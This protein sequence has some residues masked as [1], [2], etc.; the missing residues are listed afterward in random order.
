MGGEADIYSTRQVEFLTGRTHGPPMR[1]R[2]KVRRAIYQTSGR[3]APAQD[4]QEV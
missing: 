3:L 2:A 4:G 1:C